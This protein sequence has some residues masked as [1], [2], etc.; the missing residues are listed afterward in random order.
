MI[1]RFFL[2][3]LPVVAVL[4]AT[5]GTV[6]GQL[7][8]HSP[9]DTLLAET[10]VNS[11]VTMNIT[12]VHPGTDTL[13]FTWTKLTADLPLGWEATICDNTTCYPGLMESGETLPVL[14]GDDGFMLIHCTTSAQAGT[15]V[16]RYG[17][18]ERSTPLQ[19]DTLTWIITVTE[20]AGIDKLSAD[21]PSFTT[22]GHCIHL[23]DNERRFNRLTVFDL[24]GKTVHSVSI[25]SDEKIL[26]PEKLRGVFY[27]T[28]SG[29]SLI[30]RKKIF[31]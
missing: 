22:E 17:I 1:G 15:G 3:I 23:C 25:L 24:S 18:S 6:E 13:Y 9:N 11:Q 10:T 8:Y 14:P 21:T 30:V 12:Q 19:T 5:T 7:Y 4:F 27:I 16:I 2:A 26:L 31:L 20:S 28:V 29:E